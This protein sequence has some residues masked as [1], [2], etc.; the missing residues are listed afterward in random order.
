MDSIASRLVGDSRG[1]SRIT[2]SVS[3]LE[4]EMDNTALGR[5]TA[6]TQKLNRTSK[7]PCTK[8]LTQISGDA[9]RRRFVFG[10]G[11]ARLSRWS[12][13]LG[14]FLGSGARSVLAAGLLALGGD[15]W[16]SLSFAASS[17]T[18]QGLDVVEVFQG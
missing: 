5:V 17:I 9:I 12:V 2:S 10:L 14:R 15:Q 11:F 16:S 6:M 18:A 7:Q 4:A 1:V 13:L 3:M 8:M